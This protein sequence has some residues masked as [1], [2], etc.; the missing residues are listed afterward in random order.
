MCQEEHRV[1]E[2]RVF[3][4]DGAWVGNGRLRVLKF[5]LTKLQTSS[6]LNLGLSLKFCCISRGSS[7]KEVKHNYPY[8]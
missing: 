1:P 7:R 3:P 4:L 8:T 6:K 5:T 2:H